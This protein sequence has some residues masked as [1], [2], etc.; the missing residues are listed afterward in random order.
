MHHLFRN[1]FILF[2]NTENEVNNKKIRQPGTWYLSPLSMSGP[3]CLE[4]SLNY[5]RSKI[6][7]STAVGKRR[8][9]I[10]QSK[11]W[12][13]SRSCHIQ[14]RASLQKI[15]LNPQKKNCGRNH[16][17]KIKIWVQGGGNTGVATNKR[18]V[19]SWLSSSYSSSFNEY[20][21]KKKEE[22]NE[23]LEAFICL[24]TIEALERL[25]LIKDLELERHVQ[26]L[27]TRAHFQSR[28]IISYSW[29]S[30]YYKGNERTNAAGR[31][32]DVCLFQSRFPLQVEVRAVIVRDHIVNL[33]WK[34]VNQRPVHEL[35]DLSVQLI[36]GESSKSLSPDNKPKKKNRSFLFFI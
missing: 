19:H 20:S 9:L 2:F 22:E 30:A 35:I 15:R 7:K 6:L 8:S 10:I 1:V 17:G 21:T 29:S 23:E 25:R 32:R 5:K 18:C 33:N 13:K 14:L 4:F 24:N 34:G 26:A 31:E 16:M 28:S 36:R 27:S 3:A 11:V 12:G